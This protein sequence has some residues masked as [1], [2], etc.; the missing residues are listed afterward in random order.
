MPIRNFFGTM[1]TR[2]FAAF[3]AAARRLGLMS[4]APIERE[5]SIASMTVASSRLTLT[6]ACGLAT[7]TIR[8]ASAARRIATGM[9]R[10]R[11]GKRSTRLGI[12]PGEAQRSAYL[13][14]RRRWST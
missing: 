1:S 10:R 8:A 11:P 3:S 5:V 7:P 12:S 6:V 14:R 13:L 4:V 2:R 9:Y